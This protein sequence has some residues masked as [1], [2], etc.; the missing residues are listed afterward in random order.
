MDQAEGPSESPGWLLLERID[1]ALSLTE[2]LSITPQQL[3]D[4]L[5]VQ[6]QD[7]IALEVPSRQGSTESSWRG[8]SSCTCS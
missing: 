3:I 7:D 5:K 1:S 8:M 4:V 6:S 2:L